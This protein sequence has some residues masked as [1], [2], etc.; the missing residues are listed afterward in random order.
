MFSLKSVTK[1]EDLTVSGRRDAHPALYRLSSGS[2]VSSGLQLLIV[3]SS[4]PSLQAGVLGN[5]DLVRN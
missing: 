5:L 1:L 2:Q 4:G 3:V